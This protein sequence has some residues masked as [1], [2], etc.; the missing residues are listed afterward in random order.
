M[1][2][3][4]TTIIQSCHMQNLSSNTNVFNIQNFADTVCVKLPNDF[5]RN[6][7]LVGV[8]NLESN[9]SIEFED[10]VEQLPYKPWVD[11]KKTV[12]S[13]EIGQHTYRLDFMQPGYTIGASC[14]FSYIIQNNDPK[15]PYIYMNREDDSGDSSD[16]SSEDNV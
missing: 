9:K 1:A 11:I 7:E 5:P 15:K 13:T 8:Y 3:P 4:Y 12:L 14:W 2:G 10:Y 6:F 16:D